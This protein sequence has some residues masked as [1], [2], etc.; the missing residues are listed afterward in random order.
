MNRS[1]SLTA[2]CISISPVGAGFRIASRYGRKL[3]PLAG[4]TCRTS[5]SPHISPPSLAISSAVAFQRAR[6]HLPVSGLRWCA[7][8]RLEYC[9]YGVQ[10]PSNIAEH[11]EKHEQQNQLNNCNHQRKYRLDGI[12]RMFRKLHG[13]SSFHAG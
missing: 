10:M 6:Y 13:L 7:A 1:A 3:S 9:T 5:A 4:D 8:F 2:G 11:R 12:D